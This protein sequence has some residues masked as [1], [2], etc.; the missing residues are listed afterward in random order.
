VLP[1][2]ATVTTTSPRRHVASVAQRLEGALGEEQSAFSEGCQRD[3]DALPRPN[4]PLTVGLDGGYVHGRDERQR[5]AGTFEV[6]VGKSM[7]SEAT[8]KCFGFV[9]GHDHKPKRRLFEVLKAQG[10]QMNQI[11]TFLCDGGETVRE[12]QLGV[13][14]DSEHIL[15]WFHVTMRI[16]VMQ[17]LAKGVLKP[18][19]TPE[20]KGVAAQLEGI[21]WYLWHANVLRALQEIDALECELD[22]M[23]QGAE[24]LKQLAK[25]VHEFRQYIK[26]NQ[27]FIPNY[28]ERYRYGEA[29]SSAIAES[30]VDQL[31]SKRFE[32]KQQMRFCEERRAPAASGSDTG[33][34]WRPTSDLRTVV[35]AVTG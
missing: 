11:I 32:K 9:Q 1:L 35:S 12:L 3:W 31:V 10:M 4:G 7:A 14:P 34:Q 24:P 23:E 29:I 19:D 18:A 26:S 25:A 13:C 8:A 15:D 33:L 2:D 22:E 21:K 28:G 16:T 17:Q 20:Q 30:T 6:I 5:K 27:A